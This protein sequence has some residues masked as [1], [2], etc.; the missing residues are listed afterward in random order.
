[1]ATTLHPSA[2]IR[3]RTGRS[4]AGIV[5]LR[6][7]WLE[8]MIVAMLLVN[9]V[10]AQESLLGAAVVKAFAARYGEVARARLQDWERLMLSSRDASVADKLTRVNGF[11]NQ[12]PWLSD[13]EH[14]GRR[15]YWATPLEMIGTYGGDCEDFSIAK[16]ITLVKM[17]VRTDQL[18]I[19]YVRAPQLRQ[20]HMVLAY[21]PSPDAVPLILDNLDKTIRPASDRPDLIPVY[22]FNA[23]GLW[24]TGAVGNSRRLGGASRL[25]AWREVARRMRLEGVEASG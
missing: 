14:W 10:V 21:Y 25:E 11:F 24:A 19:T 23:D 18:R 22:S 8:A 12:V 20:T 4:A 3:R 13:D 1:M 17:G 5:S 7:R 6:P 16:Y 9:C 15:D 2:H